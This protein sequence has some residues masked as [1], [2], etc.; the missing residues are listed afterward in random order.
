MPPDRYPDAGGNVVNT[1][2]GYQQLVRGEVMRGKFRNSLETPEAFVPNKPTRVAFEIS[3]TFHT[4]KR[5]HRMMVQVKSSWFPVIDINPQKILN[6]N[7]ATEADFQRATHKIYRSKSLPSSLRI[8]V[9]PRSSERR[10]TL[11][12]RPSAMGV[13]P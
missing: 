1:M 8:G 4:F 13:W 5:G 2:G 12:V 11:P 9:L 10:E 7:L 3:D 6:I